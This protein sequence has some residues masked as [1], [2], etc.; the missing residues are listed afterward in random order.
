MSSS[1]S[2]G[3]KARPTSSACAAPRRYPRARG[4]AGQV[5]GQPV[6]KRS[7]PSAQ[8]DAARLLFGLGIRHVGAVTA[9]DLMK[10]FRTLAGLREVAQSA[11]AGD[12]E[13]WPS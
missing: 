12:A 11:H 3:W 1:R 2:A 13:A 9:R 10:R 8:P 6:G 4:L 5:C 7:R